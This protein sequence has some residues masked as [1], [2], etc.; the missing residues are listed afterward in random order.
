MPTPRRI[1]V[2][3]LRDTHE[4]GGPG[5]TILETYKAIDQSRFDLHIG[6]YVINDET[7]DTPFVRTARD[8]GM[9]VHFIPGRHPYDPRLITRTAALVRR[10]RFDLIHP[11]EVRSDVLTY[12]ASWLAPIPIVTTVHGYIANTKKLNR[13]FV[14]SSK[15]M[16]VKGIPSLID[17]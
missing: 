3:D 9:P 10:E 5:K 11:H 13:S 1:R 6:V 2:L 7:T 12:L 14:I 15:P 8:L 16:S 4:I 17:L